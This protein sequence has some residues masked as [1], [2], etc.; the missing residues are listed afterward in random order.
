MKNHVTVKSR[1]ELKSRMAVV[2]H[3]NIK[4]L[5]PDLQ[6]VLLDD[7][8]TALE[9][10]LIV[11]DRTSQNVNFVSAMTDSCEYETIET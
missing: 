6:S 3:E 7:L 9:S 2:F 5:S 4:M 10:R 8:V 11:L 1:E